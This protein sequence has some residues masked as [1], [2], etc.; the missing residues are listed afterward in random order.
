MAIDWTM[1]RVPKA[2]N[3]RL[4]RLAIHQDRL[5]QTGRVSLP[6]CYAERCP[7]HFVVSVALDRL[8]AH[9]ARGRNHRKR[10]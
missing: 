5:H 1:L 6:S 10:S 3:D 9:R 8:E 2:L 7:L 4:E